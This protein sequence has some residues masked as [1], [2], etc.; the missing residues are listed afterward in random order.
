ASTTIA[1]ALLGCGAT[2]IALSP[3]AAVAQDQA[4]PAQPGGL[5]EVLGGLVADG[6]LTQDQ[7]DAV[8]EAIDQA[9]TEGRLG[10]RG[11]AKGRRGPRGARGG[12]I[13]V[14]GDLG[15]DADTVRQ[16][17]ADGLTIGEIADANGS[18]AA[19]VADALV[20]QMTERL[21]AAV[22]NGRIDEADAAEKATRFEEKVDD[23]VNG[24]FEFG[25]GRRGGRHGGE[26]PGDGR[27]GDPQPPEDGTL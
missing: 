16:G 22:E 18:S 1:A 6:T 2:A 17:L 10:D 24:E 8:V 21:E 12:P 15:V 9:R 23:I 20:E 11:D 14:L 26:R 3:T 27:F 7:A 13:Q 5:S 19:A 25:K 4:E